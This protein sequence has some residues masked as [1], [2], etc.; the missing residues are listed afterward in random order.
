MMYFHHV[1]NIIFEDIL[2]I[3]LT[4]LKGKCYI[5]LKKY[6]FFIDFKLI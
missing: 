6:V 4:N 1:F 3:T 2:S 5:S